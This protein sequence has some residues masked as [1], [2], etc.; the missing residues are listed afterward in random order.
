MSTRYLFHTLELLYGKVNKVMSFD[1]LSNLNSDGAW[2]KYQQQKKQKA[3]NARE[4]IP[5]LHNRGNIFNYHR[6]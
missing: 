3:K 4:Q 1:V 2:K 5:D 6:T